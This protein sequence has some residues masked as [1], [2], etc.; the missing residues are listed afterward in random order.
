MHALRD[1]LQSDATLTAKN[2][3]I[4][5]VAADHPFELLDEEQTAAVIASVDASNPRTVTQSFLSRLDQEGAA[6]A[7]AP[8]EP[9]APSDDSMQQ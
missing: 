3:S 4:A 1:T 2:C 6:P 5:V 9:A 8:A 7:A